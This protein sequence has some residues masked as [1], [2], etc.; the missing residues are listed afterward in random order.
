MR[1]WIGAIVLAIAAISIFD[2]GNTKSSFKLPASETSLHSFTVND[3]RKRAK[4]L[5]DYKGQVVLVVNVAS[6]CGLTDAQYRGLSALK[7]Q[8][9]DSLHILAFPCNQF[10]GQEPGTNDEISGVCQM[11]NADVSLMDKIDIK[12]SDAAPVYKWL[13]SV[14]STTPGW[15]FGKF[16]VNQDGMPVKYFGPRVAPADLAA[17]IELLVKARQ[18]AAGSA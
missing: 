1:V 15:N 13:T 3:F 5:A 11:Y 2:M 14:T 8:F 16:L 4:N 6:K 12:G 10:A 18:A 9:G 17:D 7:A